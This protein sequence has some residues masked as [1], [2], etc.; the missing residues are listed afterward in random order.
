MLPAANIAA[1]VGQASCLSFPGLLAR[2]TSPR[3]AGLKPSARQARCLSYISDL[4][5]QFRTG[6]TVE[7]AGV[8]TERFPEIETVRND[9]TEA[10]NSYTPGDVLRIH[11]NDLKL[12]PANPAQGVFFRGASRPEVRAT[13]YVTVTDGQ[14]LVL[15][16]AAL[17]SPQ[18][19]MVRIKY[20][21]NQRQTTFDTVLAQGR[22]TATSMQPAANITYMPPAVASNSAT[23]HRAIFRNNYSKCL[24]VLMVLFCFSAAAND[25][26]VQRIQAYTNH[27]ARIR[28]QGCAMRVTYTEAPERDKTP[29]Q[30][31]SGN[32]LIPD[33]NQ[34]VEIVRQGEIFRF[35]ETIGGI[36]KIQLPSPSTQT[37]EINA[38][39]VGMYPSVD[40]T[41]ASSA[42][43]MYFWRTNGQFAFSIVT[44]GSSASGGWVEKMVRAKLSLATPILEYCLLPI[45]ASIVSFSNT[46]ITTQSSFGEV[47]ST[48]CVASLDQTTL[49]FLVTS[50]NSPVQQV[51]LWGYSSIADTLP[52]RVDRWLKV[53]DQQKRVHDLS[54]AVNEVK[55]FDEKIEPIPAKIA[56]DIRRPD[57]E[58]IFHVYEDNREV[59]IIGTNEVP[60]LDAADASLRRPRPHLVRYKSLFVLSFFLATIITYLFWCKLIKRQKHTQSNP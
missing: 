27:L 12:N 60:V 40:A 22:I 1:A 7:R 35:D 43:N 11:G 21:V 30:S 17:T 55:Y 46:N 51:I 14:I 38:S 18:N 26:T 6:L 49:E 53:S 23:S 24:V 39:V 37:L 58:G 31:E 13:R 29:R 41:G 4:Q 36:R 8:D 32:W 33:A 19:L 45:G 54:I 15:V 28:Q 10:P 48:S 44:N 3:A 59:Q 5:G 34:R 52:S 16:P 20:G 56:D 57:H 25:L 2:R 42:K 9:A 50:S 47:A